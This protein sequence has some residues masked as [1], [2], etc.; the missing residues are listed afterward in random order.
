MDALSGK[1][2]LEQTLAHLAGA[3]LA[4]ISLAN[5]VGW[6]ASAVTL[7]V[8]DILLAQVACPLSDIMFCLH[9][10]ITNLSLYKHCLYAVYKIISIYL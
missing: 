5:L 3:L 1:A 4:N 8:S 10:R 9:S 7:H 6:H 2:N